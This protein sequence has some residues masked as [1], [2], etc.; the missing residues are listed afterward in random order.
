M[1]DVDEIKVLRVSSRM[2]QALKAMAE[3]ERRTLTAQLEIL[4]EQAVAGNERERKQ[5]KSAA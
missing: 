3:R 1:S 2:H 4:I 5:E